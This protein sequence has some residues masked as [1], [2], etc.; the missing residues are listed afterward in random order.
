MVYVDTMNLR[1]WRCDTPDSICGCQR[2]SYLHVD[3]DRKMIFY[4][5]P[6][7]ASTSMKRTLWGGK[8]N[9]TVS[10]D[11]FRRM[12]VPEYQNLIS[13]GKADEYFKFSAIR[14]PW[15]RLVS[16]FY[17]FT[18]EETPDRDHRNRVAAELLATWDQL[19]TWEEFMKKFDQKGYRNLHWLPCTDFHPKV[20]DLDFVIEFENLQEDWNYLH[21]EHGIPKPLKRV[22]TSS[23]DRPSYEELFTEAWMNDKVREFFEKD[24]K[25]GEYEF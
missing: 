16:I 15:S 22:N 3:H 19:P 8:G 20:L 10:S 5:V 18:R 14:N 23:V 21:E 13:S 24:I 4:D 1:N 7:V 17:Y 12:E 11:N 9:K 25:A 2:N 6:R